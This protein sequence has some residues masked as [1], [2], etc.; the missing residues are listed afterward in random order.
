MAV[1]SDVV[2]T[3]GPTE[4][5]PAVPGRVLGKPGIGIDDAGRVTV[6]VPRTMPDEVVVLRAQ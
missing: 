2:R 6:A 3:I 4:L 5:L 1:R